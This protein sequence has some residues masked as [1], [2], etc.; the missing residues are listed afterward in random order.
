MVEPRP[1]RA[2]GEVARATRVAA[3]H[4]RKVRNVDAQK[5][6]RCDPSRSG[7]PTFSCKL[8]AGVEIRHDE[9][10]AGTIPVRD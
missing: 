10:R 2:G 5:A 8:A 7:L 9:L 3:P 4:A 1:S 6:L